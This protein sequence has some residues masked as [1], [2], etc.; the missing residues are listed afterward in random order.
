M[1]ELVL[2]PDE[3][4]GRHG[5]IGVGGVQRQPRLVQ[6]GAQDGEATGRATFPRENFPTL[7]PF[8]FKKKFFEIAFHMRLSSTKVL[9][10]ASPSG[11]RSET[12]AEAG[13]Q[14]AREGERD[15]KMISK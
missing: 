13:L 4:G 5:R 11:G 12:L 15:E 9:T 8:S 7:D 6:R 10:V 2:L 14:E 1:A 3:G